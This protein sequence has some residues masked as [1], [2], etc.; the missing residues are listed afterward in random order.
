MPG[1]KAPADYV[2]RTSCIEMGVRWSDLQTV[3][4]ASVARSGFAVSVC[5]ARTVTA[6][7][8]ASIG[9]DYAFA[10]SHGDGVGFLTGAAARA[11]D[12]DR[13]GTV[14]RLARAELRKH[15][16]GESIERSGMAEETGIRVDEA[17]EQGR[18]VGRILIARTKPLQ[19]RGR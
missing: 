5:V 18:Q 10:N 16:P 19:Q 12:A 9:R 17:I 3:G 4:D 2:D 6:D 7:R 15:L 1:Q 13:A 11:P 14:G 8:G